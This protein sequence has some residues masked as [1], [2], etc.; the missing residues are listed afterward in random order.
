[1]F[2]RPGAQ[3]AAKPAPAKPQAPVKQQS[4]AVKKKKNLFDSSDEDDD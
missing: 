2:K 3:A 1:M 4:A